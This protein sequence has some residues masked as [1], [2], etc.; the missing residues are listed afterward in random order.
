MGRAA[1][2]SGRDTDERVATSVV[3]RRA[4]RLRRCAIV[5]VV[6]CRHAERRQALVQRQAEPL[7]GASALLILHV[8]LQ[9]KHP[10]PHVATIEPSAP[11]RMHVFVL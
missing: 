4:A 7:R 6:R 1:A 11:S 9:L 2:V 10:A 5:A 3:H 8:G